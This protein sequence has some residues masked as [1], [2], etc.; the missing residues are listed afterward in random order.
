M[1]DKAKDGDR[2]SKHGQI[3]GSALALV[4]MAGRKDSPVPLPEPCL[5]CAFREGSMPN[6]TAGT[7]L[8]ALNIVLGIDQARGP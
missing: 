4:A 6:Q 5:T 1:N 3:L 2:P 7:G 8:I